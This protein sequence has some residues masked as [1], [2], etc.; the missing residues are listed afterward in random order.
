MGCHIVAA[1]WEL[2][3]AAEVQG[4]ELHLGCR[5]VVEGHRKWQSALRMARRR[6]LVE[7]DLGKAVRVEEESFLRLL[8]A[9]VAWRVGTLTLPLIAD[10]WFR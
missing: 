9:L 10:R 4:V 6:W 1:V 3:T 5:L 7:E 8:F 2:L